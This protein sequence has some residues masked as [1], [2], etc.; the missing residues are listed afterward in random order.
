MCC[1]CFFTYSIEGGRR[2]GREGERGEKEGKRERWGKK[3]RVGR[4]ECGQRMRMMQPYK[5][6]CRNMWYVIL[7]NNDMPSLGLHNAVSL[8][9]AMSSLHISFNILVFGLIY[10]SKFNEKAVQ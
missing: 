2:S 1:F 3:K 10:H 9:L 6:R 7:L 8:I 4:G 5:Y